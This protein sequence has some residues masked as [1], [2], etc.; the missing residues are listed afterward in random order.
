MEVEHIDYIEELSHKCMVEVLENYNNTA[1]LLNAADI[2]SRFYE[3]REGT[4]SISTTINIPD[5][6]KLQPV[7]F[8]AVYNKEEIIRKY[9]SDSISKLSTDYLIHTVAILDAY[10]EDI[11]KYLRKNCSKDNKG[12]DEKSPWRNNSFKLL[13]QRLKIVQQPSGKLSTMSTTLERYE[14]FRLLRHAVIHKRGVVDD[15]AKKRFEVLRNR[16]PNKQSIL[17]YGFLDDNDQLKLDQRLIYHVR[18]WAYEFISF[19][20]LCFEESK[21]E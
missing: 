11:Y 13:T 6:Y 18:K 19:I 8:G 5:V 14:E 3:V 2:T 7:D 20:L 1:I 12:L 21:K 15:K 17:D 16:E 9:R 4:F 10:I